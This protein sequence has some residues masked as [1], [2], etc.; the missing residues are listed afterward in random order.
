MINPIELASEF[1]EGLMT[2]DTAI[3]QWAAAG[4]LLQLDVPGGNPPGNGPPFGVLSNRDS[5]AAQGSKRSGGA[6]H[7]ETRAI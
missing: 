5:L 1:F 7:D 2:I 4:G 3:V 6:Q